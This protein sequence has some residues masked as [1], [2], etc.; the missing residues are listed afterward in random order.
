[1]TEETLVWLVC[2]AL[3]VFL[4]KAL[5]AVSLMRTLAKFLARVETQKASEIADHLFSS[6]VD[7]LQEMSKGKIIWAVTGS[8]TKAF[9]ELLT[10]V[11]I[12][13]SEA[14]LLI[15]IA[16]TFAF[17]DPVAAIFVFAYFGLMILTLQFS[18][19]RRLKKAALQS[20][21]GSVVSVEA[22][23]DLINA[24]REISIFDKKNFFV[25]K[26]R[27]ARAKV[28]QSGASFLFLASMPR[29][30]VETGLI[31]GIVIFVGFQ[32]FTGQLSSGLV[33]VGV[34]L[35][36]GV[37]I[38]ASLLPLQSAVS[39]F[40]SQSELARDA[41]GLLGQTNQKDRSKELPDHLRGPRPPSLG[42]STE[43]IREDVGL[44][45]HVRKVSYR[46]KGAS[47]DAISTVSLA[48]PAGSHV[49]IIGP[50]GAGKTTLVDLILGLAEPRAGSIRIGENLPADVIRSAPGTISFVPQKP[51]IVSGT[52]VDNIALGISPEFVD[53]ER[54]MAAVRAAHLSEF[55]ESMP[56]GIYTSVGSQVNALSGGQIQRLGLARAFYEKPRLLVLDEATSALDASSE[57]AISQ[58]LGEL[59]NDVTVIVIA[60]RLSTVQHSDHVYLLENGTVTAEGTFSYL[61][62]HV[63]MVAEY[64]NLM[65]FDDAPE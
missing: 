53:L 39:N 46:Y 3:V 36:G 58:S 18:I 44:P 65:S 13:V 22:L 2:F 57:A 1:V 62:K 27:D 55:I 20:A 64:V 45:V 21:E 32:F 31:L 37:R 17:V 28:S 15:L 61:R 54:V 50:S 47:G 19:S 60:H 8:T 51:G 52:I 38:I 4:V 26:F 10:S 40:K 42:N 16:T 7:Q 29:Y 12:F 63:P 35:T 5:I 48:I 9:S 11:S 6:N 14:A 23:D 49:A 56:E 34:F 41:L 25:S 24:Y 33:T 59:G 30:V 43:R